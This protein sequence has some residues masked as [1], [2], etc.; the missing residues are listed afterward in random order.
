M[1]IFQLQKEI[2]TGRIQRV[3]G[4]SDISCEEIANLYTDPH[5][6]EFYPSMIERFGLVEA[7][8]P[9]E[10]ARIDFTLEDA[11]PN[12][13][14]VMLLRKGNKDIGL[15]Y[16]LQNEA[17]GWE[18][19]WFIDTNVAKYRHAVKTYRFRTDAETVALYFSW[20]Q[21]AGLFDDTAENP[22][23]MVLSDSEG[24]YA[25][26]IPPRFYRMED[27]LTL[28][29]DGWYQCMQDLKSLK[30]GGDYSEQLFIYRQQISGW[31][32]QH[33]S[34]GD[35]TVYAMPMPEDAEL[36]PKVWVEWTG[37]SVIG[38]LILAV[39]GYGFYRVRK[40]RAARKKSY[41]LAEDFS[42]QSDLL[43]SR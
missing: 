4:T 31:F 27:V 9:E 8:A 41:K 20:N 3:D 25:F 13:G 34:F 39:I 43:R 5:S 15:C 29:S 21:P 19:L 1:A 10:I 12:R 36:H 7:A 28:W 24:P 11:M 23:L 16:T 26:E 22:L 17:G 33:Q 2:K 38:V 42:V 37:V 14:K 40:Y 35:G 18:A 32:A 6:N 30:M